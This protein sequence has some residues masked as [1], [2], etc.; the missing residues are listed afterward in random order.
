MP[1]KNRDDPKIRKQI[2]RIRL[3]ARQRAKAAGLCLSCLARPSLP[4]KTR[5]E[6][7]ASQRKV[8]YR[9]NRTAIIKKVGAY[10]RRQWPEKRAYFRE[11]NRKLRLK[12]IAY[13]GGKCTDCGFSDAR[14]LQVDH[15]DGDGWRELKAGPGFRGGYAR[16]RSILAGKEK[17]R[18]QLLCSNCNWIKRWE[19]DETTSLEAVKRRER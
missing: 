11:Y 12:V 16:Y 4:G 10:Q 9:R 5:C 17:G 15:K 3:A 8:Y 14:A 6:Q 13:L 19:Q 7:C 1:W 2:R 18:Y